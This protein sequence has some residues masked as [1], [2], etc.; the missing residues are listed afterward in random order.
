MHGP[1]VRRLLSALPVRFR[2]LA[3]TF[4][5]VVLG[6]D[7]EVLDRT[8]AHERAHVEQYQ[9]FGPA[10]IPAYLLASAYAWLRGGDPYRD[11]HFERRARAAEL[12]RSPSSAVLRS[13]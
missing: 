6:C 4:G 2:V 12:E 7:R 11:N 3:I 13:S 1:G 9:R 5:H 8:R 10:F